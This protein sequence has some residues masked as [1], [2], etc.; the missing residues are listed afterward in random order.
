[1]ESIMILIIDREGYIEDHYCQN[2]FR[3]EQ[4]FNY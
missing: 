4:A 1:M 2:R 3:K